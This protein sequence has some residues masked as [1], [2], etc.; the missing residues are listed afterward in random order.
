VIEPASGRI[1]DSVDVGARSALGT[2]GGH[3]VAIGDGR[4]D[5]VDVAPWIARSAAA[6][7]AR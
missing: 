6:S 4:L 3:L 5:V 1:V 7:P 2:A